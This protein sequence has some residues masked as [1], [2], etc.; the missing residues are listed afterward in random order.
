MDPA[1]FSLSFRCHNPNREG[2]MKDTPTWNWKAED[3]AEAINSNRYQVYDLT[4][5]GLIPH[6]RIGRSVRY[7]PERIAAWLE[8]GG[9]AGSD[10]G[11]A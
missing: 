5:R 7:N 10:N 9:T 1:L 6:A 3:V 8:A 11:A 4:R 2:T